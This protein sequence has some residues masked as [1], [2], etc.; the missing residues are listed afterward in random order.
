MK[1]GDENQ[2]EINWP[3]VPKVPKNM[4]EVTDLAGSAVG[5]AATAVGTV[6]CKAANV[7]NELIK[8]G[9]FSIFW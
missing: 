6:V 5:T 9:G 2:L 8:V 7:F 4:S 3:E 1:P